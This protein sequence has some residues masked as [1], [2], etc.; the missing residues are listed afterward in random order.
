MARF[1]AVMRRL[2]RGLAVAA[3]LFGAQVAASA[4]QEDAAA[5]RVQA[6]IDALRTGDAVAAVTALGSD[7]EVTALGSR[8]DL[9]YVLADRAY[10]YDQPVAKSAEQTRLD[11]RR[12]LATRLFDLS[13]AA[14]KTADPA[15]ERAKWVLAESIILKERAGLGT[16]PESWVQAAELLQQ[17]YAKKQDDALPLVYAISFLLEGAC[18]DPDS[19]NGLTGKATAISQKVADRKEETPTIAVAVAQS[20]LWAARNLVGTGK[21]LARDQV[22]DA[23]ASLK[24]YAVRKVPILE[25]ATVWND[26]VT[27]AKRADYVFTERY[28]TDTRDTLNGILEIELPVSSRWH[29]LTVPETEQTPAYDYVTQTSADGKPLRQIIFRRYIWGQTYTFDGPNTVG[30]DNVKSIAQGLQA[31]FASRVV[32]AS[33]TLS[34][35]ARKPFHRDLDGYVFEV[36]GKAVASAGE[37]ATPL[38]VEGYVVR[39]HEQACYAIL[40]YDYSGEPGTAP[41][42]EAFVAGIK[43]AEK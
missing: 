8:L 22:R 14:A 39:G 1:T 38:R 35:P 20:H 17:V 32:K 31:M 7:D 37:G 23:F 4:Q 28:V 29:L 6:A 21:K 13:A 25:A 42:I 9:L 27:W 16:G 24:R 40:V 18:A 41:E 11:A 26:A 10:R 36:E 30:G 2:L 34:P 3:L 33:G 5:K 43:E 15:D 12:T 19:A